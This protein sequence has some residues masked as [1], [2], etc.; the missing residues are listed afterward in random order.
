VR[1]KY[2]VFRARVELPVALRVYRESRATVDKMYINCFG[3]F[4]NPPHIRVNFELDTIFL[5]R[6]LFEDMELFLGVL[7]SVEPSIVRYLAFDHHIYLFS[8]ANFEGSGML[9]PFER[10]VRAMTALKEL[11]VVYSLN[12]VNWNC[13]LPLSPI[14]FHG[15]MMSGPELRMKHSIRSISNTSIMTRIRMGTGLRANF[16]RYILLFKHGNTEHLEVPNSARDCSNLAYMMILWSL[17][18]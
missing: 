5:S 3:S 6:I 7:T 12:D 8:E 1:K 18:K 10:A 13:F 2:E 15:S 4:F 9:S 17:T 14:S 11:I 16:T